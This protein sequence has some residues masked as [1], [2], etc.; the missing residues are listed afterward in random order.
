MTPIK[1][2]GGG[3]WGIQPTLLKIPEEEAVSCGVASETT[4]DRSL[5]Q[6]PVVFLVCDFLLMVLHDKC[7]VIHLIK[8][9]DIL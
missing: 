2:K 7:T 1:R 4:L 9:G 6:V 5:F 3:G 8:I